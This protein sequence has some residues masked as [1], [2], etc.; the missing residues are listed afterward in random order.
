MAGRGGAGGCVLCGGG[1]RGVVAAAAGDSDPHRDS[2]RRL[3][4]HH[5]DGA[6]ERIAVHG[7]GILATAS[8]GERILTGGDD[9][10]VVATGR[11]APAALVD[12]ADT[13]T[14]MRKVKH[15]YDTGIRASRGI[16]Y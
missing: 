16:D 7:G 13:V 3:G 14:E 9:G 2:R 12:V 5:R 4:H 1:V 15:A 10:N 6:P 11:D 8:D